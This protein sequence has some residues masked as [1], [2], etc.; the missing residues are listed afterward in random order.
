[1]IPNSYCHTETIISLHQTPTIIKNYITTPAS[2]C[3]KETI[4][5]H[6]NPH[7][8]KEKIISP[9]FLSV[10]KKQLYVFTL[11]CQCYQETVVR[12]HQTPTVIRDNYIITSEVPLS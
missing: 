1:M 11:N 8:H 2:H 7:S 4:I 5:L 12:F 10:I 6:S 9:K 3:H